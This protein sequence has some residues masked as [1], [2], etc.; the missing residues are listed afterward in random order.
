MKE[1]LKKKDSPLY[2]SPA[3][4]CKDAGPSPIGELA[5]VHPQSGPAGVH[6]PTSDRPSPKHEGQESTDETGTTQGA[7][8]LT[9]AAQPGITIITRQER[10]SLTR[11]TASASQ[12][13]LSSSSPK[14]PQVRRTSFQFQV[15]FQVSALLHCA[16]VDAFNERDHERDHERLS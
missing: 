2:C 13:P 11:G 9:L 14:A 16:C 15:S 10:E 7:G 5:P 1:E 12:S 3:V 4:C 8:T 6:P